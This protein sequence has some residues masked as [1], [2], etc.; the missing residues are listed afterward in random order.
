[1]NFAVLSFLCLLVNDVAFSKNV[2]IIGG[3]PAFIFEFPHQVS[4]RVLRTNQFGCAGTIITKWHVLT[5]AHC[6]ARMEH[7]SDEIVVYAGSNTISSVGDRYYKLTRIHI[8]PG[9]TG[10]INR[11]ESYVHDIAVVT[12]QDPLTFN[13]HQNKIDL[14][15]EDIP[16]G[17]IGLVSGWGSLT[18][19]MFVFS[20]YLQKTVMKVLNKLYCKSAFFFSIHDGQF[21]GVFT[22]GVG[23]CL[24]DSGSAFVVNQKIIGISSFVLPCAIGKPDV[25]VN[26]YYY[27]DFIRSI[28]ET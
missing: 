13:S 8:H 23:L 25:F 12:L 26:V 5:V 16:I 3:Q 21:C 18:Y 11:N 1:M 19:P 27:L 14:P 17:S 20:D 4:L 22:R 15:T 9:Y 28:I 7:A 6:F 2:K 24:G 10:I